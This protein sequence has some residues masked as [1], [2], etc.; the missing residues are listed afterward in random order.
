MLAVV[1]NNNLLKTTGCGGVLVLPQVLS[2]YSYVH[3]S[4]CAAGQ[5]Q[6]IKA[7]QAISI[8]LRLNDYVS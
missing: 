4:A 6:V 1:H 5:W 8:P 7:R 3:Y 2:G